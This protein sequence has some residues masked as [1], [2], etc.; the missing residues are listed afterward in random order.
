MYGDED[1]Y[2]I[3]DCAVRIGDRDYCPTIWLRR[4]GQDQYGRLYPWARKLLPPSSYG[5]P[6]HVEGYRPIFV[7]ETP[8][9]YG[10]PSFRVS[11]AN[12]FP[13][14]EAFPL[15]RWNP[16]T[17]TLRSEYSRRT[18]LTGLFRL[19]DDT[20]GFFDVAVGLSKRR[21]FTWEAWCAQRRTRDDVS[22]AA[23]YD[24][25]QA[26]IRVKTTA[27][28]KFLT[29][30]QPQQQLFWYS[31]QSLIGEDSQLFSDARV[32]DVTLQ[33]RHYV[34]LS[35]IA[36]IEIC[37][38]R[39]LDSIPKEV[40]ELAV[41]MDAR[42]SKLL[43]LSYTRHSLE[44]HQMIGR[45]PYGVRCRPTPSS[46][47][48]L[49]GKELLAFLGLSQPE[50]SEDAA[51]ATF[52]APKNGQDEQAHLLHIA[53]FN[54]DVA[55]LKKHL[56]PGMVLANRAK[57]GWTVLHIAAAMG[58]VAAIQCILSQ[59]AVGNEPLVNCRTTGLLETPLHLLAGYAPA[60]KQLE[61]FQALW[62]RSAGLAERNALEETP[63]H[64]A[65]AANCP[66]L[67]RAIVVATDGR[68]T[69]FNRNS[70]VMRL[71]DIDTYQP[72][73]ARQVDYSDRS[74]RS[75]LWHA[76]AAGATAA[77][78]ALLELGAQINLT[79]DEGLTP[80]H[81]AARGGHDAAFQALLI[82]G[83]SPRFDTQLLGL[84]PLHLAV[85]FGH[86]KCV[87]L[88]LSFF[89]R[90]G[91]AAV[92][93][94][95]NIGIQTKAIHLAAAG[96]HLDM[97]QELQMAG[98][99]V[100]TACDECLR[101]VDEGD[102]DWAELVPGASNVEAVAERYGHQDI[103]AFF[104]SLK[105]RSTV[106]VALPPKPESE[107]RHDPHPNYPA[108]PLTVSS[109]RIPQVPH[110]SDF[111]G[112]YHS[113]QPILEATHVQPP[114]VQSTQ[115]PEH[116]Q[117]F[118]PPVLTHSPVHGS[119]TAYYYNHPSQPYQPLAPH[120][121]YQPPQ[122]YRPPQV[123]Q[124]HE[125][126][127]PFPANSQYEPSQ[128]Y[129]W[130]EP[131]VTHPLHQSY[132]PY[133]P[134]QPHETRQPYWDAGGRPDNTSAIDANTATQAPYLER[135]E[136]EM[137]AGAMLFSAEGRPILELD[138]TPPSVRSPGLQ[139][140]LAASEVASI[141]HKKREQTHHRRWERNPPREWP[142]WWYHA[143]DFWKR[144]EPQ[145]DDDAITVEPSK[146]TTSSS[147]SPGASWHQLMMRLRK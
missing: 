80:L 95:V 90:D 91:P 121:P 38:S 130:H 86:R 21:G 77:V 2:A 28:D 44:P 103:V 129:Q 71:I 135:F 12:N 19:R 37:T 40:Q 78:A 102:G 144:T 101:A 79:D 61:C 132:P 118:P 145:G 32:S 13:L 139:D 20:G 146:S 17:L 89:A 106:N 123:Y 18:E 124:S 115:S 47:D 9:Y 143:A 29:A 125:F 114:Y 15:E 54:G 5:M 39:E 76:A 66:E 4:L 92:R 120:P 26:E 131:S 16:L 22:L 48:A 50:L 6:A 24:A 34:W 58:H 8:T 51:D 105:S 62:K 53:A 63:L 142:I 133:Q 113:A 110:D 67:I 82:R 134:Y 83:A 84:T 45:Q 85:L 30:Q 3:L 140:S 41:S 25:L 96:G 98:A 70:D 35:V 75:P 64:R 55:L 111:S 42:Y 23:A 49:D 52:G 88:L 147:S 60:D 97:V 73:F 11:P 107:L 59:P 81:A 136:A 117:Y 43:T 57:D 31:L 87:F 93:N 74:G 27:R 127:Q 94:V 69:Q 141:M 112:L 122:T 7:R 46:T 119:E 126:Y 56:L 109:T 68:N 65:A 72:E 138:C 116:M 137:R 128:Q 14:E 36:K 33:G 108:Q 104:Q 10:I 1:Y 99:V 100:D